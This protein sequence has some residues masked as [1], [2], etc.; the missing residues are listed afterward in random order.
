[1]NETTRQIRQAQLLQELQNHPH[2]KEIVTIM[3]QQLIDDNV[4][5]DTELI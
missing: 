4:S 5:C 3:K 2:R 1:M